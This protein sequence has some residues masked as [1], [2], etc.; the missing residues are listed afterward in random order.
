M[1]SP[2]IRAV[3]AA[4]IAFASLATSAQTPAYDLLL[5][6]ALIVDGTG[7]PWFRGDLA[8]KG[9]AIAAIAYS[10]N[11]SAGRVV[12]VGGAVIAPG[13]IDVHTHARRGIFDVPTADNYV[14]QGVTTVI[15]GPD[16]SS[17][18]PLGPFL[19]KLEALEK[20]PNIGSFI[21]QGSIRSAVIG[22]VNRPATPADMT[23]IHGISG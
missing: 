23:K 3:C 17:P 21:G 7:S 4:A 13:F 1:P 8:I 18:V 20:T 22:D 14:R 10:I 19:A 16:G 6:N 12:D 2:S 15:E 5:K 11:S 9:D